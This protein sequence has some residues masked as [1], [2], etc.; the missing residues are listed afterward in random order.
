MP[1]KYK[2]DEATFILISIDDI[3][4]MKMKNISYA[5]NG[6]FNKNRN[7]MKSF[8]HGIKVH[9]KISFEQVPKLFS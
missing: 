4:K 2:N 6:T 8:S 5:T 7:Q 9:Q 3:F 1:I